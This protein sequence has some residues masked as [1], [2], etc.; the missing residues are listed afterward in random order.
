MMGGKQSLTSMLGPLELRVMEALWGRGEEAR[1]RDVLHEFPGTAYTT[2]MTTLDRLH[3]K[4][5]LTRRRIGRAFAY[6]PVSSRPRLEAALAGKAV[7]ALVA[8]FAHPSTFR[9][10]L[11]S[12]VAAVSRRDELA[13]DHLEEVV[14][15]RRRAMQD[16]EDER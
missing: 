3:K 13:L 7:D 8:S 1:V 6:A 10:L 14:R 15:E 4:G 11:S 9:P 2:L 5:I 16:R 12:F